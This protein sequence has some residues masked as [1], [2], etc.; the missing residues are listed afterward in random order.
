MAGG[1]GWVGGDLHTGGSREIY[2]VTVMNWEPTAS[3]V[4][5][6][7]VDFD[8]FAASPL[9]RMCPRQSHPAHFR[10]PRGIRVIFFTFFDFLPS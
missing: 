5:Q 8:L 7:A 4:T 10:I 1:G 3:A 9:H 2:G 6:D